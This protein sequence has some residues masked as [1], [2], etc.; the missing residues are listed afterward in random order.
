MSIARRVRRLGAALFALVLVAGVAVSPA[1][2]EPRAARSAFDVDP[3]RSWAAS[4]SDPAAVMEALDAHRDKLPAE[5]VGRLKHSRR[6]L[7]RVMVAVAERNPSIEASV[8]G[9]TTWVKWY[10]DNPRFYAAVTP[11]QLRMLLGSDVVTFVEPDVRLTYFMSAST[12]DIHARSLAGD[13]T[14]VWS[15]DPAAGPRGALRSDI[16]GLTVEQATGKGVTVAITDSGIDRTHRD[17]GGWD[18][19]PGPYTPCQSRIVRAVTTEHLIGG[20]DPGDLAPTTELGSGHGSH[21][22]GTVA[23]NGYYGRDGG[24]DAAMYGA[25]GIPFGVAPEASLIMTKNGDTLWAGMSQ[26]A[27]EWQLE[28][29]QKY[30]IRVSS[31]SWGCLGGCSFN[32]GSATGRLFKDMYNA[33]IVTVFAAGND[34]GTN[35][36][37]KFSGYA[38]SPYVLG[39]AAYKNEDHRLASFSSRGSDNSLPDAATWTPESEPVNGE[40]RPDVAAP[41]VDIWSARTLTGGAASG[42][43]R[44]STAD[45]VGGRGC[46]IRD[47][48]IM[49]GTSMATPHVAGVAA[50]AFSACPTSTPLDVMRA[51]KAS[52]ET[53]ILK[54]AGS[55]TAEPFEVGYG[56]LEARAAVDWLLA[57]NCDSNTSGGG[58]PEP[59]ETATASPTASPSESPTGTPTG[60][61]TY[62]FHSPTGIGNADRTTTANSHFDTSPPTDTGASTFYD[63]PANSGAPQAIYDPYWTGSVAERIERLDVRFW[64]RAPAA[65][66]LGEVNYL[67]WVWVGN[68]RYELPTLTAKVPPTIG[69][70][71]GLVEGSFTTMLDAND[72]EIPLSIDPAGQPVT[73]T[74]AG[75]V[76]ETGGYIQYDSVA[77][78]AG[79][80]VN[81]GAVE[82]DPTES[83]TSDPSTTP[84]SDPT[85]STGERGSYPVVPNDTYF[86]KQ[87]GPVKIGAPE[88]W[89][90]K[91]ATGFG[92]N[93]AVI[94]TGLDL[95]HP[96]FAC[97]GKLGT[98]AAVI[99]GQVLYGEKA[100]DMNGHGTH[101]AGIVGACTNNGTG[102][103]GVAPDA[104]ITPYRVFTT[105]E[106]GAGDLN[107]IA[108][109]IEQA[110]DDGAHV[111]NMSL[112]IG[113]GALP[114]VGGAIGYVDELFPEIDAAIEYAQSKG[115]VV[116]IAAGNSAVL[117]L[118]EYPAIAEDAICVGATD[119]NDLKSWYGTFPNKLDDDGGFG[120]SLS[121]PGGQGTFCSDS[122]F[123]T[124]WRAAPD[125][126]ICSDERGYEAIDGT[127]MAS[128]HVAGV[129][130][131]LYDR[132]GAARSAASRETI[133][134]TLLDTSVDLGTPGYDPVFGFGRVDA[135]KAVRAIPIVEPV[136]ATTVTF[137]ADSATSGQY[138][139]DAVFA[140]RL[141]DEAG[142]P[143]AEADVTFE[144]VGASGSQSWTATTDADGVASDTRKIDQEP[145]PYQLTVRYA[146]QKDAYEGSADTTD[147]VVD[148]EDSATSL[149]VGPAT[150]SGKNKT[151]S[152]TAT[153]SD[154]DSGAGVAD[155]EISFFCDGTHVATAV[156]GPDG[157]ASANAPMNCAKGSHEYQAVFD[158]DSYYVGSSDTKTS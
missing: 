121:A 21:V 131:L 112:G 13:G 120:P 71:T 108:V 128:P 153:L 126:P 150:G 145:G 94:D 1:G 86:G 27:L 51:I 107:D 98:G 134:Q 28:N 140:A 74:I 36:G 56:G 61:T 129:A 147:F 90:E 6:G 99:D 125:E 78:P 49:S 60:G 127:S 70:A 104:R 47:Y 143:V 118:C 156:T 141:T 58:E 83:P 132:L 95:G 48:A 96:D 124:Y 109:A 26:F 136:Q 45:V 33:G 53:D 42:V 144:M 23:G 34:G 41:G 142:A 12:I 14:G 67:V 102:T 8:A 114:F 133:T 4:S 157:V 135:A 123:S 80:T 50:L 146:G 5:F 117:P 72:Q 148:F 137:T 10:F 65:N 32:G 106:E 103:V 100:G 15:F 76:D 37:A 46:C 97:G 73:I 9:A 30:G 54:T 155:R 18:C 84:T 43:P 59:T 44:V 55:A 154:A 158:G 66:A 130:A 139:D 11:D 82:T 81:A 89:Q 110:T 79:F 64:Q 92:V 75:I 62:Y 2:A 111:I 115:V 87:W 113:I 20:T 16:P 31:N 57:R 19:Q 39:V 68:T 7:L 149:E 138:S 105:A 35:D 119:R 93:V 116:V 63:L 3:V 22:A 29:A 69:N 151:R 91:Q 122:I 40:R 85:P 77:K 25:D 152:L 38:Q 52:A 101:V 24:K 17:F 88:A